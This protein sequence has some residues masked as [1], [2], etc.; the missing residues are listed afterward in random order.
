MFET[1][2]WSIVPF[3]LKYHIT[4]LSA[5]AIHADIGDEAFWEALVLNANGSRVFRVPWSCSLKW[6]KLAGRYS[7]AFHMFCIRVTAGGLPRALVKQEGLITCTKTYKKSHDE[8]N[9]IKSTSQI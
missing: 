9:G 2:V 4:D 1:R 5:E 7:K 8:A 3:I 6:E